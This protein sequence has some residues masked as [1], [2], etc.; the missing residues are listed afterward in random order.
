M[1]EGVQPFLVFFSKKSNTLLHRETPTTHRLGI[2][3]FWLASLKTVW[4]SV[5]NA[6][7]ALVIHLSISSSILPLAAKLDPKFG[8]SLTCSISPPSKLIGCVSS[9]AIIS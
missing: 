2:P 3:T 9:S 1:V 5:P 4:H 7:E 8:N 6:L